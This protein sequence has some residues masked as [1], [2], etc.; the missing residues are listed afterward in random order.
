[1]YFH[2]N[3]QQKTVPI[4]EDCFQQGIISKKQCQPERR[5]L[6]TL[7]STTTIKSLPPIFLYVSPLLKW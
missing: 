7:S 2:R 3:S 4:L 1:M 6:V 5:P